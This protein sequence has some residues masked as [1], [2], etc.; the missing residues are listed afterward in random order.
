MEHIMHLVQC[1]MAVPI[2]SE[3]ETVPG[4]LRPGCFMMTSGSSTVLSS[5]PVEALATAI[6]GRED[7]APDVGLVEAVGTPTAAS[8]AIG[9]AMASAVVVV[10]G[11][12]TPSPFAATV[13]EA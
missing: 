9:E 4:A 11:A 12:G 3:R 1:K 10:S 13:G 6:G 5:V 2:A 8:L 7:R